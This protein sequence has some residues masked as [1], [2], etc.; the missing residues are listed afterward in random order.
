M[1]VHEFL[2]KN[3][4]TQGCFARDAKGQQCKVSEGVTFCVNGALCKKHG[5]SDE[6]KWSVLG[7]TDYLR[8]VSHLKCRAIGTWNDTSSYEE[9]IK[10][11][12]ELDI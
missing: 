7:T 5:I 1:K 10:T 4:W 8:L 11:L 6:K 2:T 3:K 12:K 9:I